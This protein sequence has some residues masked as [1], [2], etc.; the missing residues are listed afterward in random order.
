M[1]G[2]CDSQNGQGDLVFVPAPPHRLGDVGNLL[3]EP[4]MD[5][6]ATDPRADLRRVWLLGTLV[7]SESTDA[8]DFCGDVFGCRGLV[9]FHTAADE[10]RLSSR[11][12]GYAA[13][14][15]QW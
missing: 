12:G 10:S 14:D 15:Y 11:G 9:H 3:F 2:E 13:R 4:A 8:L 1:V 7:Q 5:A 6:A